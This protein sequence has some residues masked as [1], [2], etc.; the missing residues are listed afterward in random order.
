MFYSK[1]I[2]IFFFV[3]GDLIN[4]PLGKE[5]IC[6]TINLYAE[7]SK[8]H[9][10]NF[11]DLESSSYGKDD[12]IDHHASASGS[13]SNE[14]INQQVEKDIETNRKLNP[15]LGG[16]QSSNMPQTEFERKP[17]LDNQPLPKSQSDPT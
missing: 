16:S 13:T 15:S 10:D 4:E 14:P 1:V 8:Q 3:V 11:M 9:P 2:L 7:T 17:Y 12:L 6:D 5:Y